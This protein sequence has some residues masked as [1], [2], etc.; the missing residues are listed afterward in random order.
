MVAFVLFHFLFFSTSLELGY[1]FLPLFG[2]IASFHGFNGL[3]LILNELG[4][5]YR[6]RELG[7]Q[8]VVA[9]WLAT[10]T[11]FILLVV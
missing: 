7:F 5:G 11:V 10:S 9:L 1:S 8:V 4:V 2:I 3:R 6:Y